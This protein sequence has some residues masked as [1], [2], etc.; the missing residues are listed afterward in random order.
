MIC[1]VF[2]PHGEEMKP[3]YA[4]AFYA[5]TDHRLRSGKNMHN[6]EIRLKL[7]FPA[8]TD[9]RAGDRLMPCEAEAF[10]PDALTVTSVRI[11][12]LGSTQVQHR[13]VLCQ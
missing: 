8:E 10:S 11:C 3:T 9:I 1:T 12:S 7:F 2:R 5:A 13:E 4:K 6:R